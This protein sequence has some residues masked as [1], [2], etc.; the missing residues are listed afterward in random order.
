MTSAAGIGRR[1]AYLCIP[2]HV[3][4][5]LI[6]RIRREGCAQSVLRPD[7]KGAETA[8]TLGFTHLRFEALL[9]AARQSPVQYDFALVAMP[10]L[11]GGRYEKTSGERA[12]LPR[13]AGVDSDDIWSVL[14][15]HPTSSI[16][17]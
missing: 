5:V 17:G 9:T 6:C 2:G 16:D 1:P 10:G 7:S 3:A 15:T 14:V 12:H 4:N 13:S 8:P 11:L